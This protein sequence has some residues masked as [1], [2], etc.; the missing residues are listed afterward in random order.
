MLNNAVLN[1]II[2]LCKKQKRPRPFQTRHF[3]WLGW[4]HQSALSVCLGMPADNTG[5]TVQPLH[6]QCADTWRHLQ[7]TQQLELLL[8]QLLLLVLLLLLLFFI[9]MLLLL[10]SQLFHVCNFLTIFILWTIHFILQT[11]HFC[12]SQQM[13]IFI[14]FHTHKR[15]TTSNNVWDISWL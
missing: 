5:S 1:F 6:V 8:L 3:P 9:C 12:S 7:Y 2:C 10:Q 14:L 13:S 4:C 11:F 15:T